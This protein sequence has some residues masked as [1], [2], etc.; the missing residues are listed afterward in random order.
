[1]EIRKFPCPCCGAQNQVD[2]EGGY[3]I[4]QI[5]GWED[6]RY[7]RNFPDETGANGKLTLSEARRIWAA[8]KSI[9]EWCPNPQRTKF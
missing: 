9:K 6:D 7:Q 4:C 5:C 8:G 2:E 3:D 1:M